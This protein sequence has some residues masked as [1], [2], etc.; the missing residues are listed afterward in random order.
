MKK[1]VFKTEWFSV[2]EENF[3]DLKHF[4]GKPFY[5]IIPPNGVI[6]FAMTPEN[7][8]IL[9]RQYR[10]ALDKTTLEFPCGAVEGS[11]D[12]EIAAR[13]E[14]LEETGYRADQFQ[15]LGVGRFML[16]RSTAKEHMYVARNA[17]LEK[18]RTSH[19]DEISEVILIEPQ[20][21]KR[22]TLAGEF[23]HFAAL[24]LVKVLEWKTGESLI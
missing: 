2:E 14:L 12:W 9:V 16:N 24:A 17:V 18:E 10:P 13:R 20:E 22:L 19:E 7:K 21:L 4:S 23:E 5:R 1:T 3:P 11:E 15:Y 8:I 6:I